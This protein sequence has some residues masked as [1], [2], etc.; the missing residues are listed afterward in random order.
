[1]SFATDGDGE[2]RSVGSLGCVKFLERGLYGRKFFPDDNGKL[3]LREGNWKD[4]K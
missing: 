2:L 3:A 1:M 4:N